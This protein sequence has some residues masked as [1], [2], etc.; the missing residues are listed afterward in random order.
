MSPAGIT[1]FLSLAEN[2]GPSW[3]ARSLCADA[4]PEAF[5]PEPGANPNAAKR[6]CAACPV[7]AECLEYALEHGERFG[8]WGGLSPEQR[9][10]VERERTPRV[11]REGYCGKGLHL[12]TNSN[13]GTNNRGNPF[14][15]TCQHEW[16]IAHHQ[17]KAVA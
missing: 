11:R 14:C 15:R 16:Y 1:E 8:V 6:L 13:T 4:D 5:F 9:E 3:M 10:R 2:L 12:R 7:R 17:P